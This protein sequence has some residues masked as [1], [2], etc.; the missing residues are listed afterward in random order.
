M[1]SMYGCSDY[2]QV[3]QIWRLQIFWLCLPVCLLLKPYICFL[4][5]PFC[6]VFFFLRRESNTIM[7]CN[8]SLFFQ[9]RHSEIVNHPFKRGIFKN[10]P[11]P[12]WKILAM[13][14]QSGF[15]IFS[16][17]CNLKWGVWLS[18]EA[19][20]LTAVTKQRWT[21]KCPVQC[22]SEQ[23]FSVQCFAVQFSV[24]KCSAIHCIALQYR[25][26]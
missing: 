9:D 19:T 22:F 10:S 11:F 23:Y 12:I 25:S 3:R 4:F 14:A 6:V 1:F 16:L 7:M 18:R 2:F 20:Q 24:I 17:A 15:R 26:E 21:K 5:C 8:N 13:K